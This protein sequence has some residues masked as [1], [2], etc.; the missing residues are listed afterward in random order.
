MKKLLTL[1]ALSLSVVLFA[2][3]MNKPEAIDETTTPVVDQ[4]VTP[5]P[6]VEEVTPTVD[7][8]LV[9]GTVDTTTPTPTPEVVPTPT[10]E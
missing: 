8:T 2:G 4:T 10:A 5:T 7:P 9:T 1:G 3:C 6:V